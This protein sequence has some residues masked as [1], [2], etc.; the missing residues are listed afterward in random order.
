MTSVVDS[1]NPISFQRLDSDSWTFVNFEYFG[2]DEEDQIESDHDHKTR[3]MKG[4][5]RKRMEL[6]LQLSYPQ[7]LY[8]FIA[9]AS[10]SL[11]LY[12]PLVSHLFKKSL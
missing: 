2:P 7:L 4:Q 11:N 6:G 9:N 5:C 3:T 1:L 10:V 8:S 12:K